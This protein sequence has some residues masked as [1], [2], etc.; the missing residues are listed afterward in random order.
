[1]SSK[2]SD[3]SGGVSK[4]G[5]SS[6]SG[7]ASKP[8]A[9]AKN[10]NAS[11]GSSTVKASGSS[12][13]G[14]GG[15][16]GQFPKFGTFGGVFTPCTLTILGVIM[17]LRFGHVVGQSG[18]WLSIG[19]VLSA[20]VIT[21]LT[22]LSLS[23]I[24]TNTRVRGGGAYYLISRSLGVEFGG[25]IG[26]V[27]FLAQAIS[28][29]MY[30]IGFTE[31]L[32]VT[33]PTL[34]ENFV[35]V[36]SVV[37]LIVFACVFVGAG[38]TIKVQYFILAIL[39]G[40][41]GAFYFGAIQSFDMANFQ[42]N[43]AP[44]FVDQANVYTM[45]ALFFPA[46]TGIM[47]GANMSGDLE[48]PSRAIPRGT[49]TSVA[50]TGLIY[51]S[52]AVLL[53][54]A[55]TTADLIHD[56]MIVRK[57]A[58][59]PWLITAGV[60]AATMS[61]ALGSMMGAPRILQAF[62]RD[63]VF[64]SL[65]FFS[66]VSGKSNEPRRA[67]VMTFLISQI[68]V[69]PGDL[70]AIAPVITMFFM[71]TYGLL[72]LAT[73]YEAITKN[74]SYRPTFHYCHWSTSLLGFLGCLGVMF[75]MNW[76]W[77]LVSILFVSGL[78]WFIRNRELES[79][80]GDLRSGVIFERARKSL[81]R[82]ESE[83]YHP[84]NWRPILMALTGTGWTRPHLPIY[85]H[86][87]TS[88]HGILTLAQVVTGNPE[89]DIEKRA[90]YEKQLRKFI[91]KE[92]LEAFP[93]VV[94]HEKLTSGI[95]SLI[96]CHGIGGLRTNTV[97]LGWPH[98]LEKAETFGGNIRLITKMKR[99]VLAARFVIPEDDDESA[100]LWSVPSGTIDVWWRGMK[101]GELMLLLAHLL[102]RNPGWRSNPIR[103]LRFVD[104]PQAID[105]VRQ[106][107]I[108]LGAASRIE[109]TPE[110]IYQSGSPDEAIQATSRDAA[111]VL[112]GFQTPEEGGEQALYQRMEKL[113]GDL[114][115]VLLVDSV[116]GME[117]ES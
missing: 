23:A 33:F 74:P 68:C 101:N 26:I 55:G 21:G 14:A 103:V 5:T 28:V 62:S 44:S 8:N 85:G 2:P 57:L 30:V 36:A 16:S 18:L 80:W 37:N 115:R 83:V 67:T 59:W 89:T 105:D 60:F 13:L 19:I 84:K 41:L 113:A 94:C 58:I 1:L 117:L 20:K 61:S 29:A 98:D 22:S 106:H 71:I 70:N 66:A 75:L 12:R 51:L 77:A 40:S 34:K 114:P 111:L 90:R 73:F 108:A 45:F 48:N 47:A 76:V 54:G 96:Q 110:V 91:V 97:L 102:H 93:A 50:I 109:F 9:T 92:G 24:A 38:W 46:V 39:G 79:R 53:S 3:E 78:H 95:E 64:K 107:L 82:L 104:N 27:F 99:S 81:L 52:M 25:A 86:W 7:Q 56:P 35:E 88:G 15:T 87:L 10:I 42:A 65:N 72:N 32:T 112:L 11:K 43:L 17:F 100:D 69:L 6:K 4:S 31:A 49:L 63:E 116:G